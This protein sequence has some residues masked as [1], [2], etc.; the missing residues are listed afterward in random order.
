MKLRRPKKR[1]DCKNIPRPCPFV[2]CRHNTFIDINQSSGRLK[3]LFD[4]CE[5][6]TD[7]SVS[8]CVLDIVEKNGSMTL[9]DVGAYMNVTRER[10]RQIGDAALRK[11]RMP[12][13]V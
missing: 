10:V 13:N 12:Q 6:P 7:M 11:I 3:I 2:G 4:E 5:D 1:E 8:N 9:E